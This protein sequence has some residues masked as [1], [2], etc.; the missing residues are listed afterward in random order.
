LYSKSLTK[1][2]PPQLISTSH[3]TTVQHSSTH[4]WTRNAEVPHI[5]T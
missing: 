3:V 4:E 2:I 1:D 5:S